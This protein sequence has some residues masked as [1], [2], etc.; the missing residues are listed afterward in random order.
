MWRVKSFTYIL[1]VITLLLG[2]YYRDEKF[3]GIAFGI[4][5]AREKTQRKLNGK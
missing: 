1:A 5:I 4:M 3:V 2:W